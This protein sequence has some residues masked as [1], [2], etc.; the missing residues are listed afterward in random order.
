VATDPHLAP[1]PFDELVEARLR[2]PEVIARLDDLHARYER[3]E[4]ETVSHVEVGRMLRE[5]QAP[6]HE[7]ELD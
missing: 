6:E 3:G 7:L 4:L 2:D 5:L 1:D